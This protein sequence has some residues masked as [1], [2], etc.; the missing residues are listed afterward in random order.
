MLREEQVALDG[1]HPV[2]VR[3]I[4]IS[5]DQPHIRRTVLPKPHY[6][7][8]MVGETTVFLTVRL[9][10]ALT[11]P[12]PEARARVLEELCGWCRGCLLTL[13]SRPGLFLKVRCTQWPRCS[14]EKNWDGTVEA[15]LTACGVPCWQTTRPSVLT[16]QGVSGSGSLFVEGTAFSTRVA[17]EVTNTGDTACDSLVL[18]CDDELLRFA[19]LGLQSGETLKVDE[20]ENGLLTCLIDGVGETR[21]VYDRLTFS[22]DDALDALCGENNTLHFSASAP[23]SVRFVARGRYL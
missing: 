7:A 1:R 12:E 9:R 20:D 17:A 8:W 11:E 6:G 18:R 3:L 22:S 5:E 2:G 19:D 21:S 10:F 14:S 16:L 23:V 4:D 13:S 15:A